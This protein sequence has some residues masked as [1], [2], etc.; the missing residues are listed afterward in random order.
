MNGELVAGVAGG[1]VVAGLLVV[2]AVVQG[3]PPPQLRGLDI[4]WAWVYEMPAWLYVVGG[5][6]T[7][8]NVGLGLTGDNVWSN[9]LSLFF[10]GWVTS[11]ALSPARFQRKPVMLAMR[12]GD[13]EDLVK[14]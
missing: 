3:R 13:A 9:A 10:T 6:V 1:L 12:A 14:P 7:G 4:T 8:L 2:L 5:A 11:T